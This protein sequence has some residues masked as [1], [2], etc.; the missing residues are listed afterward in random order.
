MLQGLMLALI[1]HLVGLILLALIDAHWP[2]ACD[3]T[4]TVGGCAARLMGVA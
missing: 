3:G 2:V 4:A 1:A